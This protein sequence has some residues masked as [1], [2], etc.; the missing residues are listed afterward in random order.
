MVEKTT[1][2][3]RDMKDMKNTTTGEGFRILHG[4]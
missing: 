1:I 2:N 4:V 3:Y